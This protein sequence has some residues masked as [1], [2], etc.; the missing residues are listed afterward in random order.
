MGNSL[1]TSRWSSA[2]AVL[3]VSCLGAAC[4]ATPD[5]APAAAPLPEVD[6]AAYEREAVE[7]DD[8]AAHHDELAARY[9]ERLPLW[10]TKYPTLRELAEHCADLAAAYR[11]A[12][13]RA[14]AMAEA[15]RELERR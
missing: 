9:R 6:A 11:Q 8:K 2:F 1:A 15:Q 5:T 13:S 7:L 14:R 10:G 12:A 4:S 3:A